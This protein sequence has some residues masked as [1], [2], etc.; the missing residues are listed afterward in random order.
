MVGGLLA[1]VGGVLELPIGLVVAG[2]ALL[3]IA[4]VGAF[5]CTVGIGWT[6]E[7]PWHRSLWLGVQAMGSAVRDLF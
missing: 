6:R 5:I 2:L 3:A 4:L 7:L 1:A